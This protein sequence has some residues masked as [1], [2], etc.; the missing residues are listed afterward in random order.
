MSTGSIARSSRRRRPIEPTD[1]YPSRIRLAGSLL[2]CCA[3]VAGF[4]YFL[5]A[6][7][8]WRSGLYLLGAVLLGW[9]AVE[10]LFQIVSP[11]PLLT[12]DAEGIVDRNPNG[13][14]R[15][16]WSDVAEVS[17]EFRLRRFGGSGRFLQVG[18]VRPGSVEAPP[19]RRVPPRWRSR[20]RVY[21][22]RVEIPLAFLPLSRAELLERVGRYRSASAGAGG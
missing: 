18:L 17:T 6:H 7:D 22:D 14:G 2:L 9:V 3:F 16:P 19:L 1:L 4:L 8:L 10:L 20:T 5:P 15:I 13:V 12:I 21:P 11:G